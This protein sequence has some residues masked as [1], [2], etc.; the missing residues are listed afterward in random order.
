MN[1]PSR[2]EIG[3]PVET[4]SLDEKSRAIHEFTIGVIDRHTGEVQKFTASDLD[5]V[6]AAHRAVDQMLAWLRDAPA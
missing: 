4:K 5:D 3:K 6:Q 2:Y 1:I